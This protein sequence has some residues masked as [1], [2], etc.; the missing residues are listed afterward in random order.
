MFADISKKIAA[1]IST[2]L[3]KYKEIRS[4]TRLLQFKVM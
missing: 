1:H 3:A 4:G 2:G